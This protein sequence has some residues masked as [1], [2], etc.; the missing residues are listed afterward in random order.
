MGGWIEPA[1]ADLFTRYAERVAK[2]LGDV[3]TRWCTFNEP[4]MVATIGYLAGRFPPGGQGDRAARRKV[5]RRL[6]RRAPQDDRDP[7]ERERRRSGRAHARDA[8]HVGRRRH[9]RAPAGRIGARGPHPRR[10]RGCV[11]PHGR[12]RRL[13]RRADLQPA[14]SRPRGHARPR[15]RRRDHDHGL[16]VLAGG[17]R[18][19]DPPGVGGH[20]AHADPRHRERHHGD[21]RHSTGRVRQAGAARGAARASTTASTSA[22]TPTGACSTTSSGPTATAPRSGSSASIGRPRSAPSSRA[23]DGSGPSRA[24][25]AI[26]VQP[27]P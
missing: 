15:G 10:S 12:G 1:T 8:A 24:P 7:E 5:N 3:A 22:A 19:D 18:G 17:A 4:N 26:D 20:E 14:A 27:V 13:H 9:A 11:S 21:R 23:P 2:H 6:R 16:R 25:N